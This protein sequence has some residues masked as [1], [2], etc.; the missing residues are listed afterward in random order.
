MLERTLRVLRW[1]HRH[2]EFQRTVFF[3]WLEPPR[4]LNEPAQYIQVPKLEPIQWN[5]FHN[6]VAPLALQESDFAMSV[7][8]DGFPLYPALWSSEFLEWDL[9]GSPW[10]QWNTGR[11][12]N[13]GFCI[14][15]RRFMAA[16]MRL[17]YV[18]P[19]I[20]PSDDFVCKL[21]RRRLESEGI[22]FAPPEVAIRFSTEQ[23]GREIQTF[24]FHGRNDQAA[25]Y[26][27]GWRA[28]E[29]SE[30]T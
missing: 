15:S 17:P 22:R 12:G 3:S 18:V 19:P 9:I 21:H 29:A 1:C 27:Q 5:V 30:G 28:I 6:R 4:I 11:V 16:K 2:F 14:E 20:L 25:K 26:R 24:G 23:T 8:E 13:M 10:A 7:H